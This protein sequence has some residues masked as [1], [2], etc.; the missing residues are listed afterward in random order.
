MTPPTY[1]VVR[2]QQISVVDGRIVRTLLAFLDS[3]P[4]PSRC[5]GLLS[6]NINRDDW[7]YIPSVH[8]GL[9]S[10]S[11]LQ[12]IHKRIEQLNAQA[13]EERVQKAQAKNRHSTS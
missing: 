5:L 1:Y 6:Q 10:L 8:C 9:L 13:T 3:P 12:T 7:F 2:P 11:D 4:D